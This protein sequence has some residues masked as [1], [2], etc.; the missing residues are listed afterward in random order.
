MPKLFEYFGLIILFYSNEHDPIH[1]HGKYQDKESKAEI[2]IENGKIVKINFKNV[3]GRKPLT[4][5]KLDDFKVIV[6]TFSETIVK[7]WIDFFVYNKAIKSKK[8]TRRL[9]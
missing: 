9:K 4:K 3:K 6:N 1:V 7:N 5:A 2:E 8:I